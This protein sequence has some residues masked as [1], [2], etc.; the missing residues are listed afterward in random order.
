MVSEKLL[1]HDTKLEELAEKLRRWRKSNVAGWEDW[2]A[3]KK[4]EI[5]SYEMLEELV[6]LVRSLN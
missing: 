3:R 4:K 2:E 6:T 5:D 1:Q